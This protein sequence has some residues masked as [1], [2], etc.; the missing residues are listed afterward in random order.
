MHK[1]I[2]CLLTAL[3]SVSLWAAQEQTF[4][5][6]KPTAVQEHHIG[7]IID[8][9]E[10]AQLHVSALKMKQLSKEQ[11][12]AFYAEHKGKPFYPDLVTMMSSGPIVV[13]VI[14]GD[15]AVKNLRDVV[16]STD[17]KKANAGTIRATF[18]KSVGENAIHASDSKESAER[19]IKF[20][21][22]KEEIFQ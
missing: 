1:F 10:K 9:I 7:G 15:N 20:F 22:T 11:A 16:G 19:E 6:I 14:E 8:M 4:S 5:M 12:E 3:A 21:F 18:G 2:F 17:P 13:M